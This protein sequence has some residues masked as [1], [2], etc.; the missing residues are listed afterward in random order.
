MLVISAICRQNYLMQIAT[1][2][3]IERAPARNTVLSRTQEQFA[4]M[5]PKEKTLCIFANTI[6]FGAPVGHLINNVFIKPKLQ[7]HPNPLVRL[8]PTVIRSALAASDF[9]DGRI[10]RMT[11]KKDE[12]G[13]V[14]HPGAVTDLGK[15]GDPAS[16]KVT[17][18]L[19][20]IDSVLTDRLHLGLFIARTIPAATKTYERS[21]T[22][23]ITRGEVSPAAEDHAKLAQ[24]LLVGADIYA[25]L[26]NQPSRLNTAIQ[27]GAA[28][29]GLF[30]SHKT[31]RDLRRKTD[32]WQAASKNYK[33]PTAS[34]Y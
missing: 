23:K 7:D 9:V 2:A 25:A 27:F 30:S 26:S 13:N 33:Q 16:D 24:A 21:R 8:A 32:A 15:V 18:A 3:Y 34:G 28:A 6:T 1:P 10:V 14:I 12:Q 17:A 19:N 20:G 11:S 4:A 22:S 31:I 29:V 5:S